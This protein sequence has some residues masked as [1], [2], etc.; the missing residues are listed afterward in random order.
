ME[1]NNKI[2]KKVADYVKLFVDKTR[3]RDIIHTQKDGIGN[4]N[5]YYLIYS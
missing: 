2:G 1:E 4:R 3:K 5:L